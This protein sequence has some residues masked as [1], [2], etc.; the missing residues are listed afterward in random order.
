MAWGS[1]QAYPRAILHID[2][3][4]FF[5]ACEVA[6]DPALRG[7]PVITGKERGIV[8]AA[9]YEAKARGV[10][11][12]MTLS[13]VKKVCPDAVI[14]PSDYETYSL[15]SNRM[16][17]IVRRY[18]PAVEEYSIDECFA[19]LTGLRRS[20]RLSY[21]QMA[22]R[23]KLELDSELG[24]TFSLGLSATKTLAKIGSKWKKPSGLTLIPLSAA[25]SYLKQLSVEKVWGIGP[26]TTAFLNKHG[27]RTAADFAKRDE[28][29]VRGQL[30]KP[31][32][33]TWRELRGEVVFELDAIGRESYQSISKT[34][35]FTPPSTDPAFVLSQLSKNIENACIKAR[36]WNL[37]TSQVAFFL[38]TQ[39]LKYYGYE[40]A[41]SHP[42]NVPQDVLKVVSEYFRKVFKKNTQYRATGITLLKL[43]ENQSPQLDLFGAVEATGKIQRVLES[44]DAISERYGKHAVFL[45]SSFQAMTHTA[46]LGDRGDTAKRVTDLFKGE[47][48]RQRLAIPMLG[49][50]K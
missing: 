46:H 25:E 42:T 40:L 45:G 3:D 20:L 2:G 43:A 30:S 5:A 48:R 16:Y 10:T 1:V 15:F 41:L 31:F 11:R 24:M 37:V 17:A 18:T 44:V 33:E 13:E 6:K 19:D 47:T 38:K 4:A 35:T 7:R 8:S 12:G 23:I 29:W 50:V 36:R 22:E 27:V 49:E 21:P 34:K 26:N 28:T 14:L 39:D 32:Y 9:T